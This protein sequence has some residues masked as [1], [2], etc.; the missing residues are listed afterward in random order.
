MSSKGHIS[1]RKMR[2]A[3][4]EKD[5]QIERIDVNVERNVNVNVKI[6][7]KM[8]SFKCWL[9][10]WFS[11]NVNKPTLFT[12]Y[13]CRLLFSLSS[14]KIVNKCFLCLTKKNYLHLYNYS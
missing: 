10:C 7:V 6:A 9:F 13:A 1:D 4:V 3:D 5:K 14:A 2:K 12:F 8:A 11:G